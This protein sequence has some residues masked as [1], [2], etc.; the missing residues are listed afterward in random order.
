MVRSLGLR[1]VWIEEGIRSLGFEK[2]AWRRG[3]V[4][5]YMCEKL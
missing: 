2:A 1:N 4:R 5:P 3:L